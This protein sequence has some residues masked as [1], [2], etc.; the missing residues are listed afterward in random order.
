MRKEEKLEIHDPRVHLKKLEKEQ[1]KP[2]EYA[3]EKII[4]NRNRIN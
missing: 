2:K 4:K 3:I 1:I